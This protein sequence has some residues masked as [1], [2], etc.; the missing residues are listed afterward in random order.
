MLPLINKPTRIINHSATLIDNI[1]CNAPEIIHSSGILV[2]DISDLPT[3][4]T[5]GEENIDICRD[6]PMASYM[7]LRYKSKKNMKIFC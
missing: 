2:N 5:I 3:I 1:F 6:V 7:K 4:L